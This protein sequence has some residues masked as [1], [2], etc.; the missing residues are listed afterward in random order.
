MYTL[1]AYEKA[2]AELTLWNERWDN[3]TGNNP[4]KYQTDI[5]DAARKAREIKQ[6]LEDVGLLE[7]SYKEK[8]ERELNRIF[9]NAQSKEIVEHNGKK[10]RRR[11]WPLEKSRSGKTVK[12]WDKSWVM[13]EE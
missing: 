1:E 2:R 13:V 10:Y 5:R 7:R 3:Y 8:L 11:Y 9:P 12:E 6:Y 4:D